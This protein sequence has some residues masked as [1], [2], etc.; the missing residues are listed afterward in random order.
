MI[1]KV[2]YEEVI[3]SI[4]HHFHFSFAF[5]VSVLAPVSILKAFQF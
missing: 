3:M 2:S 5:P 4:I 1:N